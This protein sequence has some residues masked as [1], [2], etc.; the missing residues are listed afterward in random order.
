M[1]QSSMTEILMPT[2][3]SREEYEIV[4][5]IRRKSCIRK[6]KNIL[7]PQGLYSFAFLN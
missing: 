1:I 2:F 7:I 6:N 3:T 4:K 5:N